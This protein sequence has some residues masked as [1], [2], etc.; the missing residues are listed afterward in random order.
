MLDDQLCQSSTPELELG[1]TL[2]LLWVKI[3]QLER[4]SDVAVAAQVINEIDCAWIP[5]RK[6]DIQSTKSLF[7]QWQEVVRSLPV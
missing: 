2:R 5:R 7:E 3:H 1:E 4:R 6:Q